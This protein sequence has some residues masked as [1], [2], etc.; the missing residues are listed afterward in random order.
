MEYLQTAL[1]FSEWAL[2]FAVFT[3]RLRIFFILAASS[4]CL[5]RL[6]AAAIPKT[7][8][9]TLP[10]AGYHALVLLSCRHR[11]GS[12]RGEPNN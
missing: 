2:E 8:L 3:P 10:L 11:F 7:A 4:P 9:E 6:E 1:R 5:G 12:D